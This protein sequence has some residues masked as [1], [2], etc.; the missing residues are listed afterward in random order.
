MPWLYLALAIVAEIV[1]TTALKASEGFSNWPFAVASLAC[2]ALAFYL[3][4][5]VLLSIPV[6]IAYALWAGVG[7]AAVSLVG[8]LLFGQ[9]LDL[10]AMIGI[11][12]IVGGV[13][14]INTLSD[15]VS[16]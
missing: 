5:L 14:V 7:V 2:Y 1:G 13:I 8:W 15:S 9:S 3:L 10:P 12:M 4:S 11:A 6:G 16:A